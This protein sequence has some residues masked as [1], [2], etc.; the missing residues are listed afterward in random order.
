MAS[1]LVLFNLKFEDEVQDAPNEQTHTKQPLA[2]SFLSIITIQDNFP[3][4]KA[5]TTARN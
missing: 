4:N 2:S 3:G 1:K 5:V